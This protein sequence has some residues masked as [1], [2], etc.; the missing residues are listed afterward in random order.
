MTDEQTPDR[1]VLEHEIRGLAQQGDLP[2]AAAAAAV[3]GYGP[4][5][6]GFL[7]A[8]HRREEDADEVFAMWSERVVRGLPRFAWD[9][10]FRTWAYTIARNTSSSFR[11]GERLAARRN[12]EL[13]ESSAMAILEAQIRTQTRPYLR[14]EVKDKFAAIR[15]SLPPEDQ[16]LL[17]LRID[18]GLEWKDIARVMH[19]GEAPLDDQTLTRESQ[20]LRKQFQLLKKRLIELGKR[21]GILGDDP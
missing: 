7:V 18:R 20:R 10:S 2:A 13:P 5:I 12:A 9:C 1:T 16:E 3:R 8:L 17:V 19:E 15:E 14:T 11:R 4:E 6:F 21:E